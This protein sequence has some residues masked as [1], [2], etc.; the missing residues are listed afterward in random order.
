MIGFTGSEDKNV[1][2]FL[3]ENSL[4]ETFLII[5]D[6]SGSF[7]TPDASILEDFVPGRGYLMFN[8]ESPFSIT[9]S[10]SY[11]TISSN[12]NSGW[13]M[14]GFTGLEDKNV[15]EFLNENSL[16]E[17][18][19]IIKDVSGNFWTPDASILEDF[20]PGRG[21]LMFNNESPFTISFTD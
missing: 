15:E 12:L 18:F 16:S 14:I 2:E 3:N 20:V 17:T 10:D 11:H 7:W 8:N 13:N 19:L 1:E 4:S 9:F 21:Y 5:K 6:V